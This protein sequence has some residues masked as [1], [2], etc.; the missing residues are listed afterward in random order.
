MTSVSGAEFVAIKQGIHVCRGLWNKLRMMGICISG[1][2][3]ILGDNISMV[4]IT[5]RA[6]SVLKKERNSVCYHVAHESVGM[7]ES[8][9]GNNLLVQI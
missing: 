7:G 4:H 8:L 5:A 6:E 2:S 3:Y 1:P 9:V